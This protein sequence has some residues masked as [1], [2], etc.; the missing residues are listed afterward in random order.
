MMS[1][2]SSPRT[3]RNWRRYF[4]IWWETPLNITE[5]RRLPYTSPPRGR[6]SESG[7]FRCEITVWALRSS[8]SRGYLYFFNACTG[9]R[10]SRAQ[11]LGSRFA[12][13]LWRDWAG[14]SGSSRNSAKVQRF[15][16]RYLRGVK[17]NG[18]KWIELRTYRSIACGG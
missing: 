13:R 3:I 17:K 9:E 5:P 2:R 12:K 4:K 14:E 6:V 10:N 1:C 18:I 11:A 8:T 15:I 16:L 7:P